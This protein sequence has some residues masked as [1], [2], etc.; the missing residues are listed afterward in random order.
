MKHRYNL[1]LLPKHKSAEII[2]YA[3]QFASLADRYILGQY[4]LPH[5]TLCHFL[6]EPPLLDGIWEEARRM[7]KPQPLTLTL[8]SLCGSRSANAFWIM[9]VTDQKD[10]LKEMHYAAAN[11]IQKPLNRAYEDYFPHLSLINSQD[12]N[13]QAAISQASQSFQPFQD[14]FVLKLGRSD[15]AGQFTE[16]LY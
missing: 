15:E 1:A 5:I 11:I 3:K 10:K 9:L 12:K 7:V 6:A 2:T 13:Y 14:E 8:D 4:S 16:I